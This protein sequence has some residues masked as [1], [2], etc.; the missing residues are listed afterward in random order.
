MIDGAIPKSTFEK[1]NRGLFF[2]F[3]NINLGHKSPPGPPL[4]GQLRPAPRGDASQARPGAICDVQRQADAGGAACG[5]CAAAAAAQAASEASLMLG[6]VFVL[7]LLECTFPWRFPSRRRKSQ[8][9]LG[10][11]SVFKL[12]AHSPRASGVEKPCFGCKRSQ[13]QDLRRMSDVPGALP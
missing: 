2:P 4:A 3:S 7:V 8:A 12:K 10:A 1:V 9:E 13:K 11:K 5:T 6:F